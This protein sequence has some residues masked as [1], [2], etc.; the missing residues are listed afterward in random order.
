MFRIALGVEYDGSSFH[1]WQRQK[2]KISVQETL[3]M[4]VSK[5]AFEP[6]QTVCAGRTDAGVHAISQVV[7]FETNAIR[8]PRAWVFGSNTNLSAGLGRLVRVVWAKEV[9]EA[10]DARRSATGRRYRY[11]IYNHG[12]RPSLFRKQMG[13]Y[14]RKLDIQKM[15][16]AG[17]YWIG[18]HDFSSFRAADCQSLSPVRQIVSLEVQRVGDLVLIDVMANAFLHHM[19]RN[20]VGV[21]KLIGAGKKESLWAKE[22]LE[23]RDRRSAAMTANAS[24][25]YLMEVFYPAH[26]DLPVMQN[27]GPFFLQS[28]S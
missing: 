1:G 3:E 8:S 25:L 9:P 6:I 14:Y 16:E 2:D 10:F 26:F 5:V 19:V 23:A 20:M 24:G 22:V 13:W 4:A 12:I 15:Q 7:H 11:V 28:E 27:S 21:L 17:Q 18:E